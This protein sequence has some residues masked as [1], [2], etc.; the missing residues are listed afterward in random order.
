MQEATWP[1]ISAAGSRQFGR[2]GQV[3]LLL[4]PPLG[5]F[6]PGVAGGVTAWGGCLP[7]IC[8]LLG[9][10]GYWRLGL[11]RV[12]SL[13]LLLRS[14]QPGLQA[15]GGPQCCHTR[16]VVRQPRLEGTA[17]GRGRAKLGREG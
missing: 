10:V 11:P 1:I 14:A 7:R 9:A 16:C 3:P 12:L 17:L 5:L 8:S 6:Q 13:E 15:H 4:V 2:S